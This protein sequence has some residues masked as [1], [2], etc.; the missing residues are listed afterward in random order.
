MPGTQQQGGGGGGGGRL[1]AV[2]AVL[3]ALLSSVV[4][5]VEQ[6]LDS[7]YIFQPDQLHDLAKR[8]IAAHGGDTGAI[9]K[10]IV[11]ELAEKSPAHVNLDEEW[12]FNNAGGAMGA[13]YIIHASK[14]LPGGREAGCACSCGGKES[15]FS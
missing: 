14:W 15:F 7:F 13:M 12:V 10:Y 8:G 11:D 3:T 6:N 4:W 5:M 9:V 1:L 2:L